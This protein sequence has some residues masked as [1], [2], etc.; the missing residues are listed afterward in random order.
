MTIYVILHAFL[1][2]IVRRISHR[3]WIIRQL[4]KVDYKQFL[5]FDTGSAQ[6]KCRDFSTDV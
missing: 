2:P 6:N 1:M 4:G 5:Y 3:H